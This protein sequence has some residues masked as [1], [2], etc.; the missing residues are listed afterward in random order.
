VLKSLLVISAS[1]TFGRVSM[2]LRSIFMV[3]RRSSMRF[4]WHC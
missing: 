4:S 2:E 1:V 3:L